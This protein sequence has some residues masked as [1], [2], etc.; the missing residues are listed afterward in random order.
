MKRNLGPLIGHD[1]VRAGLAA[2]VRTGQLPQAILFHGPPGV[3]KQRAALWLGQLL[4][5]ETVRNRT[6]S[7][8][9]PRTRNPQPATPGG[10]ADGG[11]FDPCGTCAACRLVLRLEHPDVHWF[12]PLPRPRGASSPEKLADALEEARAVELAAR[13]ED[14]YRSVLATEPVGLY[15]AHIQVLRRLAYRRPAVA[16][17]KV[18]IVGDAEQL[19]SQE[20]SPEAAN[21]LLKL[22]EEPPPDTTFLLTTPDPE[23]LLPTLRSRLL[24]I[25]LRTLSEDDVARFLVEVRGAEPDA[26]GLAARLGQGAIGQAIAFLPGQDGEATLD[27]LRQAARVLLEAAIGSPAAPHVA[28]LAQ[29]PAGAR[30][31]VFGATLQYLTLWLRDAAA[32]ANGAPDLVINADATPWLET[33]VRRLPRAAENVPAAIQMVDS[34]AQLAQFNVNPQL[35]TNWLLRAL[36]RELAP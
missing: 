25:R 19:V 15:L 32:V 21:A 23:A 22:L 14:P 17:R 4:V 1:D 29:P 10:E 35:T 6:T 31:A 33:L 36:R 13:R 3:G 34:A 20:A 27:E 16:R 7:L 9:Q 18:F 12:F 11:V 24:P 26:A 2:A 8:H 28:A 30:S 5:C